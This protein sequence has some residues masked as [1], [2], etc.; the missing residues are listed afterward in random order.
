M[1]MLNLKP[2]F[3]DHFQTLRTGDEGQ[4]SVSKSDVLTLYALPALLPA[5]VA[6]TQWRI[7]GIGDL[8]T[9]LSLMSGLLFNLLVL[10]FDVALRAAAQ[11]RSSQVES[12]DT[13]VKIRLIRQ[14]QANATYGLVI[15]LTATVVLAVG[16]SLDLKVFNP[17]VTG[18]L[19]YLLAHFILVLM[20][21]LKRIRSI[22]RN[23]FLP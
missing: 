8:L 11:V 22:F 16:A 15:A 18:V 17:W 12:M 23:E 20:V 5:T 2:V 4:E 19:T 6:L 9:A 10:S 13:S 21:I 7:G 1:R 3:V 14:L